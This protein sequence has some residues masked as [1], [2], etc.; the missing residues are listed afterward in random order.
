MKLKAVTLIV[1]GIV[2]GGS[3]LTAVLVAEVHM[4]QPPPS[5]YFAEEVMRGAI[6]HP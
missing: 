2:L 3:C 1:V 6:K 5:S 4:T